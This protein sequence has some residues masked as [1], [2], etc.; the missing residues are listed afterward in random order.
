L[1]LHLQDT[2]VTSARIIIVIIIISVL[3]PTVTHW[4][5]T[6]CYVYLHPF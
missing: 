1:D 4:P 2:G 6:R 3:W 5:A